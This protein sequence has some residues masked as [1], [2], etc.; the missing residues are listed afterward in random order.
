M[1]VLARLPFLQKAFVQ[2]PEFRALW[3]HPRGW[4]ALGKQRRSDWERL[5]C[6]WGYWR[7][8]WV[9]LTLIEILYCNCSCSWP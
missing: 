7:R 6:L 8:R 9:D 5:I 4:K 3:L 1:P 2:L